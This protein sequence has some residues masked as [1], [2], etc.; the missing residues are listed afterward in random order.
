M[1]L[2]P[3]LGVVPGEEPLPIPMEVEI[4]PFLVVLGLTDGI[5]SG[6]LGLITSLSYLPSVFI[7]SHPGSPTTL[8][9]YSQIDSLASVVLQNQ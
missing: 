1:F 9:I 4:L 3:N 8:T 2:S 5:I 6:V 7:Q